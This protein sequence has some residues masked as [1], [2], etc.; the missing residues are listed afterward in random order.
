MEIHYFVFFSNSEIYSKFTSSVP[1]VT[2]G[3]GLLGVLAWGFC[4]VLCAVCGL[5]V[6]RVTQSTI[7]VLSRVLWLVDL[8]SLPQQRARGEGFLGS[9]VSGC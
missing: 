5:C 6:R 3:M 4:C 8:Y 1:G 7:C 9:V 2:D